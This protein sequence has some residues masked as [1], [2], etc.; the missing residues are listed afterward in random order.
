MEIPHAGHNLRNSVR[1]LTCSKLKC[2]T[3]LIRRETL[4]AQKEVSH[5]KLSDKLI[6]V[7]HMSTTF[8]PSLTTAVL[9]I[10]LESHDCYGKK[11]LHLP[12]DEKKKTGQGS[13]LFSQKK[14]KE[15]I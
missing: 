3:T 6:N 14:C 1:R 4:V 11:G 2:Y 10:C 12:M 5:Q 15:G 9:F 13:G 8:A 7:V